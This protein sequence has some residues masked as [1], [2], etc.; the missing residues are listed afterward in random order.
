MNYEFKALHHL[1]FEWTRNADTSLNENG[2][3][4]GC[5]FNLLTIYF[6]F[7]AASICIASIIKNRYAKMRSSARKFSHSLDPG[8]W[9]WSLVFYS[10]KNKFFEQTE[11]TPE[12]LTFLFVT[13][14]KHIFLII[15]LSILKIVK[16]FSKGKS[17]KW[18][19]NT[20]KT[21]TEFR[22]I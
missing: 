15:K 8:K 6:E 1:N 11:V 21:R 16:S 14:T 20:V 17:T 2:S 4:Y 3:I 7:S 9:W 13:P 22:S 10:N 12:A 5:L 19:L 18:M